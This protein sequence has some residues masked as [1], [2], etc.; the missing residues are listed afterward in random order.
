MFRTLV[1]M[2]SNKP[3]KRIWEPKMQ[4]KKVRE[5]PARTWNTKIEKI[6]RARSDAIYS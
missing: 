5:R 2:S 4:L 6:L 1:R 3:G